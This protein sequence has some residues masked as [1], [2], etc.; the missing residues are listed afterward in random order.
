MKIYANAISRNNILKEFHFGVMEFT[1]LQLSVKS[2]LFELVQN[3]LSMSFMFLHVLE[4]KGCHQCYNHE[5]IQIFLKNIIHQVL[6]VDKGIGK[7]KRHHHI[8]EMAI[9]SSRK[10]FHLSPS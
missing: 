2:N 7:A 3:K 5:I 1:F 4:K 6:K 8:F 9:T 10:N